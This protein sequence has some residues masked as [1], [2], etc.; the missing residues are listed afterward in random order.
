[1]SR[2]GR[3]V[4]FQA[5]VLECRMLLSG[6]SFALE[7]RGSALQE[8]VSL[9]V[10]S[11]YVSQSARS[12]DVTITRSM[13]S[14]QVAF[15]SPLTLDLSADA[16]VQASTRGGVPRVSHEIAPVDQS[17]TIPAGESTQTVM[18]PINVA[19]GIARACARADH[20]IAHIRLAYQGGD[21]GR[22]GK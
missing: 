10:P 13:G 15:R 16:L 8:V 3:T 4:C 18:L 21:H 2:T 17:V 22:S 5:E 19:S 9:Q 1:M 20:R 12:I 14:K 11:T 7:A 6:S